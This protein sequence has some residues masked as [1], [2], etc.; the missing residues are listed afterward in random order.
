MQEKD[1]KKFLEL[2]ARLSSR[3]RPASIREY[4][5][6]LANDKILDKWDFTTVCRNLTAYQKDNA[7]LYTFRALTKAGKGLKEILTI[8]EEMG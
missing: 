7:V 8:L 6:I 3:E 2:L 1:D 4:K 5:E